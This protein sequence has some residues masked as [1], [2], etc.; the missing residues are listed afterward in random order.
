MTGTNYA[1]NRGRTQRIC[2]VIT[3]VLELGLMPPPAKSTAVPATDYCIS[4]IINDTGVRWGFCVHYRSAQNQLSPELVTRIKE[5]Y[6]NADD[7]KIHFHEY[8]SLR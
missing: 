2:R 6:V 1:G 7:V 4:A 8:H 3:A 5:M